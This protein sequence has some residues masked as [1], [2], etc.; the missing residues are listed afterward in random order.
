MIDYE[1]CW[2]GEWNDTTAYG[3]A[4]RHRRRIVAQLVKQLP[5]G[6]I[7]DLGCGDGSLLFELSHMIE[8]VFSG[9]DV[10]EQGLSL[11]KRNNPSMTFTLIDLASS[12]KIDPQDIVIM[13]E[14][15]E[16]IPDDE[17]VL[18]SLAASTRFVVISVPGGPASKIDKRCGHFRNYD[19]DL[20]RQKLERSGFEVVRYFRWGWPFHD[21]MQWISDIGGAGDRVT[22]GRFGLL[23]K[24]MATMLHGLY[25]LNSMRM[26]SQVFAVGKSKLRST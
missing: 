20:L 25:Y 9:A 13:S 11:A 23:T 7:L 15:L 18:K 6:K 26:G 22:A 3:P 19:Q 12:F 10:S 17:S 24:A 2:S 5:R 21:L 14:V 8:G 1:H 16:H 4:C